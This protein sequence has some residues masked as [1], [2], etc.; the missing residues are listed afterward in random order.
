M[1]AQPRAGRRGAGHLAAGADN[2]LLEWNL[3]GIWGK[4]GYGQQGVGGV[5][6]YAGD[7]KLRGHGT[8]VDGSQACKQSPRD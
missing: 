4:T 7:V 8:I 5:Q 1:Q 6:S 2:L 3:T